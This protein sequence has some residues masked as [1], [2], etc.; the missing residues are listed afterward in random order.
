MPRTKGSTNSNNYHYLV[1]Q[2]NDDDKTQLNEQRYFKTQSEIQTQ[3]SMKRCSVYHLIN[4]KEGTVKRQYKN[5]VVV[6][7]SPPISIYSQVEKIPDGII[8]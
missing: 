7:L 1:K 3:Y 5:I 4:G 2:Y 8:I 6:K